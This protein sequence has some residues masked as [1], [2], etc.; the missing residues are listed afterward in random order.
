MA[1]TEKKSSDKKKSKKNF[2]QNGVVPV[3]YTHLRAPRDRTR[4]RMPSSA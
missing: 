2:G 3:S 1:K 4:S